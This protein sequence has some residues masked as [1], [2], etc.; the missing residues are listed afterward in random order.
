[1]IIF[2]YGE[3]GFRSN[4]KLASL[5]N[6]F[7]KEADPNGHSFARLNGETASTEDI[8]AVV[9]TPSLFSK[10]RM[11]AIENLFAN[12]KEKIFSEILE[13]FKKISGDNIIVL[14][15]ETSGKKLSK[16]KAALF[17][18]L[19]SPA[20]KKSGKIFAEEFAPLSNTE[21]SAWTK[22]EV[23]KRGGKISLRTAAEMTSLLGA[24]LW[25]LSGEIDKLVNYKTAANSLPL[26]GGAAAE[27]TS[28][29]IVELVRGNFDE[30]I[31]A[32]TDAIGNNNKSLAARLFEEQLAAGL[33]EPYL[34]TMITRQ[35]KIL[36]QIR[37]A[38]DRGAD[39]RKIAGEL[40]LHPFV[41][42][43]GMAQ[44]GKFS[45]PFLKS[46]FKRLVEV[47]ELMKTGQAGA[48]T[49]LSLMIARI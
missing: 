30:N 26:K 23:E 3:D 6:K 25:R 7:F 40:K 42:K 34:L 21:A 18:Y 24:D 20:A 2:L 38:L 44:A 1:M 39:S 33:A 12:K 8:S 32:L 17:K 31:F 19:T 35:F 49:M 45:L 47:D 4:E 37:E 43:K 16:A 13:F 10:K 48:K 36:L 9:R 11:I 14:K 41:V 15:D 28:A 29:D 46:V 27:I 22:K 5:K